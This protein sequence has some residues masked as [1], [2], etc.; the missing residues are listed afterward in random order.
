MGR[1]TLLSSFA[2]LML[3][4]CKGYP[5]SFSGSPVWQMF[6][7]DGERTWTYISTDTTLP[8][9]LVAHSTG[10]PEVVGGDNVYT[11]EYTSSCFGA[12]PSC[13][14]GEVL[15][16]V[17]WSSN[18][19]DGVFVHAWAEGDDAFVDLE[20][21]IH[22]TLDD[23]KRGETLETTTAGAVWTSTMSG[24]EEC[25]IALSAA[26]DECGRFEVSVEGTDGYPVAGAYWATVGNGIAAMELATETGVWQLSDLDCQ[27]ENDCDGTW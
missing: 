8:Y 9:K 7:F 15:R 2:L 10:E 17:K 18:V 1:T 5:P 24:I 25:P 16:R 4:A 20:P 26:W 6:P 3:G 14:D 11:I 22:V 19:T 12:D 21:P 23:M 27:T 13:I